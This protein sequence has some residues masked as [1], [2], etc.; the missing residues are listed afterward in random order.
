[1]LLGVRILPYVMV[2]EEYRFR[3]P[4]FQVMFPMARL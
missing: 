1:M 4:R 3:F 2:G